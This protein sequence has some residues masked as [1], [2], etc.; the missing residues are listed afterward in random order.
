MVFGT[1]K[2]LRCPADVCFAKQ[3][4]EHVSKTSCIQILTE[5]VADTKTY[6]SLGI[7]ESML[8]SEQGSRSDKH[9]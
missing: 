6:G 7:L 3:S 8:F 9:I 5:D 4:L 1:E 2:F